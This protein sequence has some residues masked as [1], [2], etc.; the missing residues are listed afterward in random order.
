MIEGSVSRKVKRNQGFFID[1]N[2]RFSPCV[3]SNGKRLEYS[4][5]SDPP[6]NLPSSR[7]S[8]LFI[9]PYLLQILIQYKFILKVSV[10]DINNNGKE[11]SSSTVEAFVEVESSDLIAIISG[12]SSRS[13]SSFLPLVLDASHS[14]DPDDPQTNLNYQW[15]CCKKINDFCDFDQCLSLF[16]DLKDTKSSIYSK[17]PNETS[18]P[19]GTFIFSC[20]VSSQ[21]GRTSKA[22]TEIE[23]KPTPI[24][25]VSIK[26]TESEIHNFDKPLILTA[27]VKSE[28]SDLIYQWSLVEGNI[29]LNDKNVAPFGTNQSQLYI[30]SKKLNETK[31]T[32][33]F[34][35]RSQTTNAVGSAQ[36]IKKINLPP[37]GGKLF[38]NVLEAISLQDTI[39][40]TT[41][42]WMD[43][44]DDLPLRYS[45]Y[46]VVELE[47]GE[48]IDQ[49]L[50][51]FPQ[52]KAE[53][54]FIAPTVD[55]DTNM[56]FKVVAFDNKNA[57]AF[58][59][60]TVKILTFQK[61]QNETNEIFAEKLINENLQQLINEGNFEKI[62][63]YIDNV[64]QVIRL[65]SGIDSN[66]VKKRTLLKDKLIELFLIY[67]Y[68]M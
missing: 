12:G 28:Y 17:I 3:P 31:Y 18:L 60:T 43:V 2:A 15:T 29:D 44:S 27:N 39:K 62:I 19:D 36:I 22:N 26:N 25:I 64:A 54:S 67:F 40:L 23:I 11:I 14:Y 57:G 52:S 8:K 66:S 13:I 5:S 46:Q 38:S 37:K 63:Q 58:A 20:N 48:T 7:V 51:P 49:P 59:T 56:T 30:E 32:F 21:D 65:S 33:K 1:A 6:L 41:S 34:T 9:P 42:G 68:Q 61:Q 53:F 35:A 24:P 45:F 47:N 10:I 16:T 50:H 55:K 4:W